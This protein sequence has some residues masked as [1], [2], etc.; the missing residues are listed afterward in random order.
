MCGLCS[1][2]QELRVCRNECGSTYE[3]RD[4]AGGHADGRRDAGLPEG[5]SA[6]ERGADECGANER[7]ADEGGGG[8]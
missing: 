1:F 3:Q 8:V 2:T 4:G 7:G 6:D 5:A